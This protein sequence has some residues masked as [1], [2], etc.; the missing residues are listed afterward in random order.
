[1]RT[2]VRC[3][4]VASV[5]AALG[6]PGALALAAD[7]WPA[8]PIRLIVPF[9]PGGSNDIVARLVGAHLTDRLGKTVVVDN[10]PGAAGT[11]GTEIAVRAQP[12]GHTLLIISAAYAYNPLVYKLPYD[13]VKAIT[14]VTLLGTGPTSLLVNPGVPVKSA[15]ELIAMAKAKPGQVFYASAGIGSFTHLSCEL[16]RIMAD[17]N[18]VHVPFKGGGPAML[19]VMSGRTQYTMGTIVQGMPHIRSGRLKVLGVGSTKRLATLPDTPTI[20]ESG[21]PGYAASNWWGII[22][23]A[24]APPG[25]V[26]RL[27]GEVAA[28]LKLPEMQKWFVTEGAEPADMSTAQFAKFILS[29]MAK[30]GKVVKAAG[31]KAE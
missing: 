11:I 27:H 2:S 3:L 26:K 8:R 4:L 18:V 24:G 13:P 1:M 12:D 17:I 5:L 31:I 30:W 14:P 22:A 25:V 20:A 9:P 19:E 6:A 10:R 15:S 7:A 23:P 21:V 28:I 16:F 29:E